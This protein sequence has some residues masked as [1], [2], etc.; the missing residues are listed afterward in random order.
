[1]KGTWW[2]YYPMKSSTMG[3]PGLPRFYLA[4]L[5]GISKFTEWFRGAYTRPW[6]PD[7]RY[8]PFDVTMDS[9]I[10]KVEFT[11]SFRLTKSS[12]SMLKEALQHLEHLVE[13]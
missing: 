9:V 4:L 11:P 8:K 3:N 13:S 6:G 5:M 1:M 2:P 12:V 10:S 7:K